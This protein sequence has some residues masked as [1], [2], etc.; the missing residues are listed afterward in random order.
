MVQDRCKSTKRDGSPCSGLPWNGTAH[1]WFHAPETAAA[2]QEGRRLGG[3]ARSNLARAAKQLPTEPLSN[4]EAHAWLS[5][6]FKQTLASKME[7]GVLNALAGA[8]RALAELS[9]VV[10]FEDELA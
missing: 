4:A 5:L 8:A 7:P 3:S 10:S 1:C 9:R 2:R 6:A